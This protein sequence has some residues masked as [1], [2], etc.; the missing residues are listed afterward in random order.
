MKKSIYS[1]IALF[2]MFAIISSVKAEEPLG[3]EPREMDIVPYE[4]GIVPKEVPPANKKAE[5]LEKEKEVEWATYFIIG[6]V[7][8]VVIGGIVTVLSKNKKEITET[9]KD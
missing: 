6:A 1:L 4:E 2:L 9:K 3:I 8:V 5:D 7:A